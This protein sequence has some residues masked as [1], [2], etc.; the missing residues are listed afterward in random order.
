MF[1][2]LV[3]K[4]STHVNFIKNNKPILTIEQSRILHYKI[5]I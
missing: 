2:F 3:K 5:L 1:G 4:L